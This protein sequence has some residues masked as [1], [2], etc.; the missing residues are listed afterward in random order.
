MK[1][2]LANTLNESLK[3][4]NHISQHLVCTGRLGYFNNDT[5]DPLCRCGVCVCAVIFDS[6]VVFILFDQV[7]RF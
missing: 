6:F 3:Y 7:L 1:K 2:T 4:I 5:A